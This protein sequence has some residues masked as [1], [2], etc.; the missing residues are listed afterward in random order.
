MISYS[1]AFI[2][3]LACSAL[4][5]PLVRRLSYRL[6]L[7]DPPNARKIHEHAVPRTGGV[8]MVLAFL[9]PI[10]GIALTTAAVGQQVYENINFVVGIVVG[11]V[12]IMLVGLADDLKGL[13]AKKKLLLQLVVASFAFA[14]GFRIESVSLPFGGELEMG[15]F[16]Y[17]ITMLWIVGIV[18]ALNLIDGLD[19]LAAGIAFLVLLFNFALGFAND[20]I[21]VCLIAASLA[22]A[23]VGFL[24]YNFNPASIFM[25]DAGS[26]FIGYVLALGAMN[27]G[28]KSSTTVALIAPIVA[29][30]V[31]IMD[32]L[33]SMVRRFL[34]RRPIFSPDRG[35]IHHRLL[36][37]GINHRR[38][39]L[40]LY[41]FSI[42]LV[43]VAALVQFGQTWQVGL[44]L[45]LMVV[46]LLIFARLIGL[47]QYVARRRSHRLGIR[48]RHG[49]I[50]RKLIFEALEKTVDVRSPAVIEAYLSWLVAQCEMK[51][52]DVYVGDE[53]EPTWGV[54]NVDYV[55]KEREPFISVVTPMLAEGGEE[56]GRV[57]F[58]WQSERGKV[59]SVTE[60]LLQVIVDRLTIVAT[61]N[62]RIEVEDKGE[63]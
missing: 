25:G 53:K 2:V 35:H 33:F 26:M 21:F 54:E 18:N 42:V 5:T 15:F 57:R 39:V 61:Q 24:F 47:A 45:V 62:G 3:A 34:E 38:V 58:G 29:M 11:G 8:A 16:S 22:G 59:T 7:Y 20:S 52:A 44:G 28:Q 10:V 12:A 50:L 31:P 56:L 37:M 41:L 27:S 6:G 4:L 63:E 32:T 55:E 49:E 17:F 43:L 51:Y 13:G 30:G 60:T 19:G 1:V 46:F 48:T 40:L 23:I 14:L 36:A 9:V